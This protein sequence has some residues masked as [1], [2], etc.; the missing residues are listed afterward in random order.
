MAEIQQPM[1]RDPFTRPALD[2]A[3]ILNEK[4]LRTVAEQ[5]N[6]LFKPTDTPEVLMSSPDWNLTINKNTGSVLIGG[7]LINKHHE[8]AASISMM[9][10]RQMSRSLQN[11]EPGSEKANAIGRLLKMVEDTIETMERFAKQIEASRKRTQS[12]QKEQHTIYRDFLG[13]ERKSA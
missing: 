10:L 6:M 5:A 4:E 11:T 1:D 12:L 7:G 13:K 2:A 9:E 8:M 3:K